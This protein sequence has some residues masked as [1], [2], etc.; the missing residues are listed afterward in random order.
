MRNRPITRGVLTFALAGLIGVL[1]GTPAGALAAPAAV[2]LMP[3]QDGSV[4]IGFGNVPAAQRHAIEARAGASEVGPLGAGAY[5][6]H[7][8]PGRVPTALAIVIVPP[9]LSMIP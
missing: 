9:W 3:Y 8:P 6:L 4:L 5:L 7:V 1:P 2:P